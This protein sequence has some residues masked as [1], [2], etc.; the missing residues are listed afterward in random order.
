MKY[1]SAKGLLF[2][3]LFAAV[4]G[5]FSA[6]ALSGPVEP[7]ERIS[8]MMPDSNDGEPG[9]TTDGGIRNPGYGH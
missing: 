9:D 6:A 3:L 5:L 4:A 2:G 8:R 7:S 1:L